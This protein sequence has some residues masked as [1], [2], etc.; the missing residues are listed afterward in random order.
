MIISYIKQKTN[1]KGSASI[2]FIA[3]IPFVFLLMVM[4]WQLLIGAYALITAQSAANE[5]AK[6]YSTTENQAEATSAASKIVNATGDSIKFNESR[7]FISSGS[8]KQFTSSV[9][10]DLKLVF[11]PSD[12]FSGGTPTIPIDVDVSSRVIK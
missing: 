10:V 12:F 5:A 9:G 11:I 1:E 3:M 4:L 7:T 6:V 8:D 2:E